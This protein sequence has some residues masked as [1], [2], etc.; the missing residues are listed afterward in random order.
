MSRN[1]EEPT[2]KR[3]PD[4]GVVDFIYPIMNIRS[5]HEEKRGIHGG[6]EEHFLLELIITEGS[7]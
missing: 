2:V 6:M 7:G 4:G 5:G 3:R 1:G